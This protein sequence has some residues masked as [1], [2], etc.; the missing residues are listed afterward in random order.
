VT[1]AAVAILRAK[2]PDMKNRE[3]VRQLIASALDIYTKGKDDR[4]GFGI[5]RPY[6]PLAGTAP[7]GTA[8]PVFEEFDRWAKTHQPESSKSAAPAASEDDD[9]SSVFIV[10]GAI[11]VGS[12]ALCVFAFFFAR[13]NRG[14]PQPPPMGPG[15]GYGAPPG[16]G[17]QQPPV[18]PGGP[19]PPGP[20]QGGL[21][22][23]Q[24]LPPMPPVP[25][26]QRPPGGAPP[27][28]PPQ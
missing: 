8:N 4:T 6:R 5:I 28:G 11:L 7:K 24:P 12:I 16:F 25:P 23:Y 1:S 3:V 15:A 18:G 14:G 20:P 10:W 19:Y 21:P 13:R 26:G 22:Q 9:S 17:Q 2:H 27:A